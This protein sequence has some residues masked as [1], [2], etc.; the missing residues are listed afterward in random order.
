MPASQTHV[1]RGVEHCS[2]GNGLRQMIPGCGV[3]GDRCLRTLAVPDPP[4]VVSFLFCLLCSLNLTDITTGPPSTTIGGCRTSQDGFWGGVPMP[5]PSGPCPRE[6]SPTRVGCT[7]DLTWWTCIWKGVLANHLVSSN[8]FVFSSR[9]F[10]QS[11]V[12]TLL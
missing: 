12:F 6:A 7:G 2:S 9:N 8:H 4:R 3:P 10:R 1:R 5:K 11:L